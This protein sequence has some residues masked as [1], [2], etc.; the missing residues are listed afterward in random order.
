MVA[1]KHYKEASGT[2]CGVG[3]LCLHLFKRLNLHIIGVCGAYIGEIT[4]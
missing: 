2:I 4:L 1:L 3:A